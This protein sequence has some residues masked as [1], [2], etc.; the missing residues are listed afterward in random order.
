[1]EKNSSVFSKEPLKISEPKAGLEVLC[2]ERS[3]SRSVQEV[4]C[5]EMSRT[6]WGLEVFCPE[7]KFPNFSIF[8]KIKVAFHQ[9]YI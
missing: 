7:K 9:N 2:P 4:L 6:K 5:P 8:D 3:T 1:L